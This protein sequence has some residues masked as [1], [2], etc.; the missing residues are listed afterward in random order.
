M[1][2]NKAK[3]T[4]YALLSV[5]LL[6]SLAGAVDIQFLSDDTGCDGSSIGC[7]NVDSNVC[8]YAS[9]SQGNSVLIS[10]A[11]NTVVSNLYR[12]GGCA[13]Y[14]DFS[15]GSTC[16][17]GGGFTG[18]FWYPQSRRLLL[19]AG[20][21]KCDSQKGADSVFYSEDHT[22]GSWVLTSSNADQLYSELKNVS[23]SEKVDWLKSHGAF[24]NEHF[25]N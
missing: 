19:T 17:L 15:T 1:E 20:H 24:Y 8:C 7:Y 6:A 25:G 16:F 22:K 3:V 11:D 23:D 21:S 13:T 14:T 2:N 5:L 12:D 4:M 18:A 10:N 9:A